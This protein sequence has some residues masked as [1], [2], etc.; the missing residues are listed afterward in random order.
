M[1]KLTLILLLLLFG[2]N[3]DVNSLEV[4]Q[5]KVP[6]EFKVSLSI[7]IHPADEGLMAPPIAG[8]AYCPDRVIIE[9]YEYLGRLVIRDRAALG[10]EVANIL[11]C[12]Y[13]DKFYNHEQLPEPVTFKVKQ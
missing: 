7:T 2:C 11:R 6:H 13:P 8:R 3:E 4:T 9:G 1:T 5:L 10:H 12:Q